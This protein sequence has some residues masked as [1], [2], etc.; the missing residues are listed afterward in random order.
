MP[1]SAYT[2]LDV[3]FCT[4][5][6]SVFEPI[7]LDS[8]NEIVASLKPTSCPQDVIPTNFFKQGPDLLSVINKCHHTGTLPNGLKHACFASS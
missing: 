3:P 7:T 4:S 6:L 8:L 2:P 1:L 5:T